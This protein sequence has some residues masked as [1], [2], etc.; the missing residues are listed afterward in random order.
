MR[1]QGKRDGICV[2][3]RT[4]VTI[5]TFHTKFWTVQWIWKCIPWP[6]NI[7][8]IQCY[9]NAGKLTVLQAA[10]RWTVNDRRQTDW[11]TADGCTDGPMA[12]WTDWPTALCTDKQRVTKTDS[13][14]V[15][16]WTDEPMDKPPDQLTVQPT[17]IAYSCNLRLTFIALRRLSMRSLSICC[18]TVA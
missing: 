5:L 18:S 2:E 12:L 13:W 15:D 16:K 10:D 11:Q 9:T 8:N 17:T 4:Y 3:M 14:T 6:N 1:R 7:T